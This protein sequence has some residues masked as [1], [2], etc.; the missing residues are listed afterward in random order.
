LLPAIKPRHCQYLLLCLLASCR[1]VA[2]ES[3]SATASAQLELTPVEAEVWLPTL[4]VEAHVRGRFTPERCELANNGAALEVVTGSDGFRADVALHAGDNRVSARC[5]SAQG[6]S[7]SSG[8][9]TY[10]NRSVAW[11]AE[12]GQQQPHAWLEHATIYGVVP[13]LYGTP[14]LQAVTRALPS[15]AELG[16]TALWLSPL[17]GT[18]SGDFGYAVTDY[19]AVRADYGTPADLRELVSRAHDLG[20]KILLDFV[21]N[22]TSAQH[23]YFR[24]AE[25]LGRRSHYFGFYQRDASGQSLH[26]F[27]WE[28]LPN[29]DYQNPE[30]GAW[31]SAAGEFWLSSFG[32]DGFRVDAAWG[33]AAREP[34]FYDLL[35][36]RLASARPIALVAEASARDPYYLQHGFDAAYD[37]TE[38]LGHWAWQDV[39]DAER[40]VA[41]RLA[42]A[43]DATSR[44]TARA[45]RVLRF[46]NNNDTG[47][48]FVTRHGVELT[49]AATVLLFTVPGVPC[50]FSFDE[51]GGEFE[52]Y[53]GLGPIRE[54]R[55]P[56]LRALHRQLID[57]RRSQPALQS[58]K[59]RLLDSGDPDVSL[60]LRPAVAAAPAALVVINWSAQPRRV[61]VAWAAISDA[62]HATF[63]SLLPS[64]PSLARSSARLELAL[65]PFGFGV[66]ALER[67]APRAATQ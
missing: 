49:R 10:V 66:W 55:Y 50:L 11:P 15:L 42:A 64:A 47:A 38:E 28:H 17:A 24:Q 4:R 59:L 19:F 29:L 67:A 26:Y 40:G 62:E 33:V 52:P 41:T 5:W 56:E 25:Q 18:T 13:P 22:H 65:Q 21:P 23:P 34:G 20:L 57:L 31:I 6:G 30:V 12:L 63:R 16:V 9:V 27:D 51:V 53:A 1:G 43:L 58:P 37:W 39:F 2:A 3:A 54:P 46:L 61:G 32:V 48:R 60:Y 36:G 14:P 44:A 45:D 7:V 8:T 35:R